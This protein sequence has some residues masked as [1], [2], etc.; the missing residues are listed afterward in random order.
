MAMDLTGKVG[1][2]TG[3]TTGIGEAT[4]RAFAAAGAKVMVHGR[5]EE[6]GRK[7]LTDIQ[8]LG[9]E[10]DLIIGDVADAD[11]CQRLVDG[12]VER[13]GRI[14]VLVNNAG[15]LPEGTA[16]DTAND[17]WL[18]C[19]QVNVNAVFFL[20]RAAVG[21][22]VKQGSGVIVNVSSEWGLNGEQGFVAY[23]TSKAAVMQMT[24]CMALDHAGQNIRINAVCPGEIHTQMVEE[25][26][27]SKGGD[28]ADN[29]AELA[30]GIPMQRVARPEEVA[31]CIL[32]LASDAS[33]Y[34]TGTHLT[35]DGG[36][37]ATAGPYP[38]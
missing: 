13:F 36:N 17:T 24:R 34:V 10:A 27:A 37:D 16:P 9:V 1:L 25:W 30:A 19:M 28:P 15:I 22:M 38:V 4:A 14:D 20:S 3:S 18:S 11:F 6:R 2:V 26:L 35:V 21:A 12:C 31:A 5:N 33:S 7:V 8:A 23:C 32:F 29:L